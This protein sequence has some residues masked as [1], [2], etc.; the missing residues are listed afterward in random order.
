MFWGQTFNHLLI[1]PSHSAHILPFYWHM[2]CETLCEFSSVQ[3]SRSVMFNSLR[4]HGLQHTRLPCPSPTPEGCSNSC[5]S[6]RWCHPTISSSVTPFS[7][8]LQSFP[9]L[10][11]FPMSQFFAS[12]VQNIAASA[13]ASVLPTNILDWFPLGL[14]GS[15]SLQSKGLSRVFSN[16][17]VQKHQFFS[18]QLSYGPTLTSI[19]DYRKNHSFD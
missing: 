18:V 4:P 9:T 10:G 8:W 15:I 3:F 6:S 1:L 14:T 19:H 11:S 12:G 7:S 16:T 17:T 13:S 5:L 2:D